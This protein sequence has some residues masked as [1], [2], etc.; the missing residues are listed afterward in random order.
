MKFRTA[1]SLSATAAIA[2][3]NFVHI[4]YSI[5][6]IIHLIG[7]FPEMSLWRVRPAVCARLLPTRRPYANFSWTLSTPRRL[8]FFPENVIIPKKESHRSA[9]ICAVPLYKL[10][11]KFWSF[12]L[13]LHINIFLILWYNIYRKRKKIKNKMKGV[14]LNE[15]ESYYEI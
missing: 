10:H 1:W 14:M 12:L 8:T 11:K 5:Q 15:Q 4:F 3:R 7:R 2:A 6:N 9:P 13:K